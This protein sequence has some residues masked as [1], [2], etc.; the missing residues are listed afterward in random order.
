MP[1]GLLV[2]PDQRLLSAERDDAVP[3]GAESRRRLSTGLF[4]APTSGFRREWVQVEKYH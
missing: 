2:F 3:R 4:T 1:A